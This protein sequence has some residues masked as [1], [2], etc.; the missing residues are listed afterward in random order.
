MNRRGVQHPGRVHG[1]V[2]IE[3]RDDPLLERARL[4][5]PDNVE[6]GL[7]PEDLED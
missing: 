7:P 3:M 1:G 2:G 6:A 5:D 4:V